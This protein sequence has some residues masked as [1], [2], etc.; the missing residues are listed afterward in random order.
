MRLLTGPAAGSASG[1]RRARQLGPG[2]GSGG[3][4]GRRRTDLARDASER[5]ASW[6]RW[7]TCPP[8]PG[9]GGE[10][11]SLSAAGRERLQ[12]LAGTRPRAALAHR[13]AAGRAGGEVERAL[14][15]DVEVA[16]PPGRTPAPPAPT[17]TPSPTSPP[18]SRPAPTGRR[19]AAFLPGSRRP[20]PRS[21]G[22]TWAGPR[23]GRDAV[24]VLTVHAAK[25]LEW[26]AVAVPGLVESSFPAHTADA[27]ARRGL[28]HS[29]PRTG[30]GSRGSGLPHDLR[31]DRDS[32][33]AVRWSGHPGRAAREET[34]AFERPSASTGSRRN[35][36]WPTSPS[37][38]PVMTCCS[39]R[40]SGGRQHAPHDLPVPRG[41]A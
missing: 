13:P 12:R 4:R 28:G 18:P 30:G 10:G 22:W 7:T 29:P 20:R 23:P 26:D 2:S 16:G 25:G 24:Q 27:G 14:W 38:G 40:T 5:P 1:P 6:R 33:P 36:G 9:T 35:G 39:P 8:R 41:G 19:S 21:A 37:P 3:A 32:L 34:G 11:G 31:G 17:S 15:L